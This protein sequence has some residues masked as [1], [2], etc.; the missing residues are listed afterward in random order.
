MNI[1]KANP[2]SLKTRRFITALGFS[3]LILILALGF[4]MPLQNDEI[5]WSY[6]NQRALLDNF[7]VIT[8]LPQCQDAASFAKGLPLTLYP[9][10][11]VNHLLFM[12]WDH[13]IGIRI[14]GMIRFL[15]FLIVTWF[16]TKP[17]SVRLGLSPGTL[18]IFFV[19][20]L[21]IDMLPLSLQ[22]A[23]PE[24]TILLSAAI[25][26][27]L[28]LNARAIATQPF[29]RKA[30]PALFIV[31]MLL[32]FPSHPKA[33]TLLPVLLACAW[34]FFRRYVHNR[35]MLSLLL[36][37]FAGF[38]TQCAAFW[39]ERYA[40]PLSAP[41][42]QFMS[43]AS[44]PLSLIATEP[45][46]FFLVVFHILMNAVQQDFRGYDASDIQWLPYSPVDFPR[47]LILISV[48]SGIVTFAL[49]LYIFFFCLRFFSWMIA[50]LFCQFVKN[51]RYKI[52]RPQTDI[53]FLYA[54]FA[55]C[56]LLSLLGLLVITGPTRMFY[57]KT[58]ELP[59]L[60]FTGMLC[61]CTGFIKP[62]IG[63]LRRYGRILAI[64]AFI[65]VLTLGYRYMPY[66]T[67]PQTRA[68]FW[69][70]E[71]FKIP[72][73]LSPWQ[74]EAQKP[75]IENAYAACNMPPLADARHLVLDSYTYLA[76]KRSYQPFSFI[77]F[78]NIFPGPFDVHNFF[79]DMKRFASDGIILDCRQVP[80]ALAPYLSKHYGYCCAPAKII[81]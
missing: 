25:F 42:R 52:E 47:G 19:C 64:M 35:L 27:A 22:I 17:L 8:L 18:Y 59:F 1:L 58:L 14:I 44:L 81:P 43:G 39:L 5:S 26:L 50:Q 32:C 73:L 62:D 10:A 57:L 23:R 78:S 77:F 37:A 36:L 79:N 68:S 76:L 74:L 24:Q 31:T 7:S 70:V 51:E 2:P 41:A 20:C 13:P 75:S 12:E 65:N 69:N 61:L 15:L 72:I 55:C 30:C 49:N 45:G 71:D 9:H 48:M 21:S 6:S 56:G 33:L 63:N 11:I 80:S 53:S 29:L 66:I 60:Y 46:K 38:V 16:I 67:Q 40:C 54:T 34:E 4:F 28:G 3:S